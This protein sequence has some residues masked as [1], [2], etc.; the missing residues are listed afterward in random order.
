MVLSEQNSYPLPDSARR[1][2][3]LRAVAAFHGHLCGGLAFA[4]RALAAA[5]R[6][7]DI[8]GDQ[9][10]R[11]FGV[12]ETMDACGI[13]TLQVIAG[14]TMGRGNLMVLDY[15]KHAYTLIDKKTGR[16]VRI[17]RNPSWSLDAIDPVAAQMRERVVKELASETERTE[18][19]RRMERVAA[20]I[21]A[22]PEEEL[23]EIHPFTTDI[24]AR[25]KTFTQVACS[26]CGE[27]VAVNRIRETNGGFS[28]IPCSS[29]GAPAQD[30]KARENQESSPRS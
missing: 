11:L 19:D 18:F 23:F 24:P 13:D 30:S 1:M 14:C 25:Q 16:A 26:S 22:M 7:L 3:D 8:A 2:R 29:R 9:G 27:M 10:K 20:I 6:E 15:G 12:V 21:L 17:V 28:C 5:M 4:V